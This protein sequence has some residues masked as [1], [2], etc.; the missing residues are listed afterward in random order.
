MIGLIGGTGPEGRGLGMRFAMA[1][2]DILIGSRDSSRAVAAAEKITEITTLGRVAGAVNDIVAVQSDP[3]F[4][5]V[6]YEGQRSTLE[7]MRETL[8][9]KVVVEVV[10]PIGFE[11]R[12]AHIVAVPDGSAAEEAQALLPKSKVV[13]AF[14]TISAHDLLDPTVSIDS[15]IVVCGDDVDAKQLIMSLS[16][17]ICG[18]RAVDG[19]RLRNARYVEGFTALLLN[20]NRIYKTQSSVRIVGI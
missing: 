10:A 19:G 4:V 15:D 12:V 6:P 14:Q 7:H 9:G 17:S 3:V 13:A 1:G 5:T 2:E 18:A 11:K 16:N 8:A 20:I